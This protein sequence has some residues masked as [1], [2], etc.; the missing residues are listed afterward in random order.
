MHP[1]IDMTPPKTEVHSIHEGYI[2]GDVFHPNRR[3][4]LPKHKKSSNS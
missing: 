2:E 3:G 1:D 4:M